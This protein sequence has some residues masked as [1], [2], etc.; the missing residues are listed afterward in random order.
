MISRIAVGSIALSLAVMIIAFAIFEGFQN[1][2]IDK[3]TTLVGH[4]E[5]TKFDLNRSQEQTPIPLGRRLYQ[6]GKEIP[7]VEHIQ[8]SIQKAGLLKTEDEVQ[9]ALLKGIGN[10][11][12]SSRFK[13]LI[14]V[15]RLPTRGAKKYQKEIMLSQHLANQLQLEVN[16]DLLV[17][18]VQ[19]PPRYRKLKVSGIYESGIEEFDELMAFV[20]IALL[21]KLNNWPDTLT[22]NYEI[23]LSSLNGLDQQ[24]T[25]IESHMDYD[26][27]YLDIVNG[28]RHYFDWFIMLERNVYI[29]ISIILFVASFNVI[30]ALLI[31]ITERTGM[32]GVLRALGANALQIQKVFLYLGFDLI[33]KGLL[34]GNLIGLGLCALQY[35]FKL[36]P[37]DPVNYYMNVVPISFNWPVIIFFNALTACIVFVVLF[38]PTLIIRNIQPIRVI[39]FD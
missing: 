12:D 15:G 19:N 18:F 6:S 29:L 4:I 36:I 8:A 31:L 9:G 3:L 30:A 35:Y 11:F 20:D 10:D 17:Y 28:Q 27:Q 34:I 24:L 37:L 16:D 32:I 39:R 5:I 38:L 13:P 14:K 1:T 33:I 2:I 23:F 26:M 7:K 21:R 25:V 22:G